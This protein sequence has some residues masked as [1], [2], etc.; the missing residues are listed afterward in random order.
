M[1]RDPI[2]KRV[3][4]FLQTHYRPGAPLLLGVSG[5]PDSLALLHLL[6]EA[7]H[8]FPME[9]HVAHV[10]HGWRPESGGEAKVLEAIVKALELPFH[11]CVLEKEGD[12]KNLENRARE[13]RF[14]FFLNLYKEK[15]FQALLLGHQ[16]GDAAET[17]LKRV[18]EGASLTSLGGIKPVAQF[19][20]MP[21]WRPLLKVS[22]EELVAWLEKRQLAAF[23][24]PTNR[25]PRFL[26]AR[27]REHLLPTL[28]QSFGKEIQNNLCRLGE[29]AHEMAAY[30]QKKIAPIL[31]RLERTSDGL[32]LDLS[33]FLP[34]ET[35]EV[36]ALLK[37]LA[38]QEEIAFSSF[39][40]D[41]L[42]NLND[43]SIII[44]G[45]TVEVYNGCIIIQR[46]IID[47]VI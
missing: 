2:L 16:A 9:L 44:S 21:I 27:M 6:V 32:R 1:M 24:D 37:A 30:L 42:Q 23:D 29:A 20:G 8:F 39:H 34:L 43:K 25:D 7:R 17:V 46:Q 5:G 13:G 22:K 38:E 35:L 36:K 15:G 18:L 47:S 14:S 10:D 31:E 3:V 19:E 12:N 40:L 11:L 26:R 45:K 4:E 41:L 33:P 28:A